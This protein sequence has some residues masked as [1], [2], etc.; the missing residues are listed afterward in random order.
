MVPGGG[1]KSVGAPAIAS[2]IDAVR[3]LPFNAAVSVA[4]WSAVIVPA[5]A[6]KVAVVDPAATATDPGTVSAAVLLDSVTVPPP[7][8]DSVT[9]QVLVPPVP[10]V[11]GVHDTELTTTAVASEIDAVRVLPFNAAVSVAVWSAAIVPAV[12]VKVAVVDPAATATDP[13]TVSAAVLLDSVTVPP[14]VFDSVTV[15]V[16]VAAGCRAWPACSLSP[17]RSA[18]QAL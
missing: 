15:Q 1:K 11:A 14:P 8:F 2:E 3:V 6:V 16:L 18:A 7:V 9:V 17:L 5:V 10:R 13:G 4:V 12:A